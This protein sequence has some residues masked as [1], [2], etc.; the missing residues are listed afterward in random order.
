MTPATVLRVSG[1]SCCKI[2]QPNG[3]PTMAPSVRASSCGL[4]TSPDSCGKSSSESAK[5]SIIAMKMA[6]LPPSVKTSM[7]PAIRPRPTPVAAC[8]VLP[9]R[10]SAEAMAQS[11]G[12][13]GNAAKT[14]M[15]GPRF[16]LGSPVPDH[17]GAAVPVLSFRSLALS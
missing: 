8:K 4:S 13:I 2:S 5:L 11:A 12:V 15:A 17:G 9:T 14:A 10:I 7:G 1:A 6:A 16:S 3:M